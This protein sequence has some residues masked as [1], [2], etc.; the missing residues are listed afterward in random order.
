MENDRAPYK[1][2]AFYSIDV[3][4]QSAADSNDA[5]QQP[6]ASAFPAEPKNKKVSKGEVQRRQ[7][8]PAEAIRQVD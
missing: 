3:D 2:Q 4:L 6:L 8:S 7:H 5:E 1:L